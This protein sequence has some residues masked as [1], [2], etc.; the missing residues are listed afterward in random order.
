MKTDQRAGESD[1]DEMEQAAVAIARDAS[2]ELWRRFAGPLDVRY[3]SKRDKDPVTAAD[4]AIEV[5]VRN[6]VRDRF[7]SH[8]VLGEEGADRAAGAEFVWV[9]DPVDGTANFANGMSMFA[10]SIGVLQRGV[11]VAAA[12][13]TAFGPDARPCIMHARRGGGLFIDGRPWSAADRSA[14]GRAGLV[15]VP[16]G[17]HRSFRFRILGGVPPGETRSLGSIAV[18]MGLA[19]AGGL[20]YAIFS[21]PKVWD[22]AAGVLLVQEAGKVVYTDRAGT[23]EILR[24]FDAPAGRPLRDWKQAVIAGDPGVLGRLIPR[25]RVR[26]TPLQVAER[27]IGPGWSARAYR[28]AR[29]LR[30]L[31]RVIGRGLGTFR[32]R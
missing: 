21:S 1:L 29:R 22:V 9:V 13:Y 4:E 5:L 19:A 17:F 18:E 23:W 15:G 26:H 30:P 28:A 2:A 25:T 11:P 7:P 31:F 32:R 8:G 14:S 27:V 24:R 3:K 20:Q 16:A 6:A 12:L 10:V